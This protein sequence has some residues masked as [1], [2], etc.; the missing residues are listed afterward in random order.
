M[1]DNTHLVNTNDS[2]ITSLLLN[3]KQIYEKKKL[4]RKLFTRFF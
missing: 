1:S 4:K 2:K 3:S